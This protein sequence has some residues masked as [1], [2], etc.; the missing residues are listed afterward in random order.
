M[1]VKVPSLAA[2]TKIYAVYGR[3][4]G[5]AAIASNPK[6]VWGD[7][8]G[9]W[10]FSEASGIVRDSSV[11]GWNSTDNGGGTVSNLNSKVGLARNTAG[12]QFTIGVMNLA[13]SGNAK[14]LT[15]VSKFTISGWMLS[16]A[17][18]G[19]SQYPQ[20]MRNK[21]SWNEG[22]GW[23][24]GFEASPTYFNAVG[25]GGT[26]TFVTVP[27]TVYNNWI[28]LTVAYNGGTVS[29]YENG[30][31]VSNCGINSVVASTSQNLTFARSLTGRIDEF[32]IRDGVEAAAYVA[33]D[34]KTMNEPGF[35]EYGAVEPTGLP[36]YFAPIPAQRIRGAVVEPLVALTN[37]DT[38]TALV[39][40][41]DYTVDYEN[42]AS[43]GTG[44]AVVTGLGGYAAYTDARTFEILPA[45]E[46]SIPT[47]TIM[48]D[49]KIPWQS[50]WVTDAETGNLLVEGTDYQY[51]MTLDPAN[52]SGRAVVTGLGG[53]AGAT[54]TNDFTAKMVLL[55]GGYTVAEEGTGLSWD[56]PMSL[57]PT[58]PRSG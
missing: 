51:T 26:R 53:Y 58:T 13:A 4:D 40:N 22:N 11:N 25:S 27:S 48:P 37:T 44:R 28:H 7:Y 45:F 3:K 50:G 8:V 47:Q 38:K 16:T 43:N 36:V 19:A 23:F 39:L 31:H 21:N 1:W 15:A 35:F 5:R 2:D 56:S 57:V 32:R 12:T 55:V 42:N 33:A 30:S 6:R 24:A 14:P 18:I 29:I 17:T 54:V 34:Y 52:F 9:V 46:V 20:F 41:T 49:G 10:H